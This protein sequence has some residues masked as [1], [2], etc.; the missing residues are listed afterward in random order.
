[1]QHYPCTSEKVVF[2]AAGT[3]LASVAES[4]S[5]DTLATISNHIDSASSIGKFEAPPSFPGVVLFLCKLWRRILKLK[6]IR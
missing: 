2:K 3:I 5:L 1:M 6:V 4:S